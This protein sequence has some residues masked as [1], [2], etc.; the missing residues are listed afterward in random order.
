MLGLG[1]AK[2]RDSLSL[3]LLYTHGFLPAGLGLHT[4]VLRLWKGLGYLGPR[5][6][7]T[8]GAAQ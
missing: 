7:V 8:Y 4:S 5:W 3:L 6:A 2:H 1:E